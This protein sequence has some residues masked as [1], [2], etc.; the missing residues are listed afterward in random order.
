MGKNILIITVLTAYC[1]LSSCL[2]KTAKKDND[3]VDTLSK[4]IPTSIMHESEYI[5]KQW[6][7]T[8]MRFMMDNIDD[9]Y[10]PEIIVDTTIKDFRIRYK[11]L[12]NDQMV[13][14][15]D[16][17]LPNRSV[18]LNIQYNKKLILNREFRVTD[19]SDIIPIKESGQ[20]L[21]SGTILPEP[22]SDSTVSFRMGYYIPDTDLG[23]PIILTITKDGEILTSLIDEGE[24]GDD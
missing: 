20:Y 15:Y 4:N 14:C 18:F 13:P 5:D 1:V 8:G 22:V 6:D 19:F 2:N 10:M 16:T 7:S 24:F 11:V 3:K 9:V 23:Y 21:L 17:L 12:Y